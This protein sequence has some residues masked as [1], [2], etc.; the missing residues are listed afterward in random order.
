M[1]EPIGDRG[2]AR[3]FAV[4]PAAGR[5]RRLG[6]PKLLLEFDG[7]PLI[8]RIVTA[9]LAGGVQRVAVTVHPNDAELAAR[10][11]SL[12]A[13][14]VRPDVAPPD[15]KSSIVFA[16]RHLAQHFAPTQEDAWLLAPADMPGLKGEHVAEVIAAH[17]AAPQ[18]IIV[19]TIQGRRGHPVLFPWSLALEVETLPAD[20][21]VNVLLVRHAVREL[22]MRDTELLE[23]LDTPDDWRR[24]QAREQ[25]RGG[26]P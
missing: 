18:H 26:D 1:D 10:C 9:W 22:Q 7:Q 24:W 5:S 14:V 17:D 8:D 13:D 3:Y 25:G 6:Q 15:M 4:V 11:Q 23:D 12:G 19:P 16:L 21:G 20:E 2:G